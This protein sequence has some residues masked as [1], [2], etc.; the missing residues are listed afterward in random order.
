[1]DQP[2]NIDEFI[3]L[4]NKYEHIYV[5]VSPPRC[6]STAFSRVFWEQPSI[7]YYCHEP[8]EVTY[9]EGAPL[10]KVVNKLK[11]QQNQSPVVV[12]QPV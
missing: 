9:F 11:H 6:S 2:K 5:I 3:S 8:F 12:K 4:K 10:N 1:M 7:R